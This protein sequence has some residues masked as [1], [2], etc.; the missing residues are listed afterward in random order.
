MKFLAILPAFT[1]W[2]MVSLRTEIFLVKTFRILLPA[3]LV[4]M[5]W[6]TIEAPD[7]LRISLLDSLGANAN[8]IVFFGGLAVIAVMYKF[9]GIYER[10]IFY[11][12]RHFRNP[13]LRRPEE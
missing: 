5:L 11:E 8:H 6:W 1:D 13:V 4:I 7:S 2:K 9:M 12:S 3:I 10:K